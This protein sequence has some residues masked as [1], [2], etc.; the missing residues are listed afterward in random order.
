MFEIYHF[1][2]VIFF[3]IY[4]KMW[5]GRSYRAERT[6]AYPDRFLERGVPCRSR[7]SRQGKSILG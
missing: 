6:A 4:T 1:G 2:I 7:R 5:T 3:L